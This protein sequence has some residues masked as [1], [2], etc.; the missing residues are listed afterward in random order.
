MDKEQFLT[1]IQTIGTCEDD[2]QRRTLLSD[3]ESNVSQLFDTNAE[4]TQT[5]KQLNKDMEDLRAANL[6]L[7]KKLGKGAAGGGEPGKDPEDPTEPKPKTYEDLF[8]EN[9]GLK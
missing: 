6:D 5:N 7:F 1:A 9:G 4:L 8:D 2:A 3:M